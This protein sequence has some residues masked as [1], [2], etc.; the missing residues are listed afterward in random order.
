MHRSLLPLVALAA[1][2][3]APPSAAPVAPNAEAEIT[4]VLDD[5]HA[6]AAAADEARY[7]GHLAED[8]IFLG[9][10]ATER[11]DKAAFRAYAHP[12]F[13]KGKAW[14]FRAV[15]RGLSVHASGSVAWFDE[16][17]T[18][19]NLGPARGSGALVLR[20]GRWQITQYNLALTIPNER[21]ALVK[22]A[23]TTA[24]VRSVAQGEPLAELAWLSGAWVGKLPG[25]ALVEEHWTSADGGTLIG[26][27][28]TVKAGKT[29]FFE[30]LRIEARDGKVLYVAQ[31]L[32]KPATE[33]ERMSSPVGQA[34]FANPEHDWPKS[35][36]Y[37]RTEQGLHVRVSGGPGERVEEW[38]L[39][40]ALVERAKPQ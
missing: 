17:L 20:D 24:T 21:F 13:A 29:E 22:E 15:R 38:T 12:H 6:A 39:T 33:F 19:A 16:E 23:A 32:G 34:L 25:G 8:S 36:A 18:T 3:A 9:T 11:W 28:R 2:A 35:I 14:S 30:H 37:R 40:P 26:S 10:D 7:F 31:P 1:C 4:R 27:G 5:F